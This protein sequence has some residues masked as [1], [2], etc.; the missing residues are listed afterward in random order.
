MAYS[1]SLTFPGKLSWPIKRKKKILFCSYKVGTGNTT[2][3]L[4]RWMGC[5][6]SGLLGKTTRLLALKGRELGTG[7]PY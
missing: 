1:S 6:S 2:V 4:A 7:N 3:L 5:E